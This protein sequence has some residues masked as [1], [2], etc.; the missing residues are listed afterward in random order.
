V[1]LGLVFRISKVPRPHNIASDESAKYGRIRT[2]VWLGSGPEAILDFL[3]KGC[4]TTLI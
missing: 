3:L 1:E 4:D 2:N